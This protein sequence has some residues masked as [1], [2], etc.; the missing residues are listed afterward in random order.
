VLPRTPRPQA[1]SWA[2]IFS[3]HGRMLPRRLQDVQA[4]IVQFNS[5]TQAQLTTLGHGYSGDTTQQDGTTA[6]AM[7]SAVEQ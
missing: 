3:K 5:V 2:R 7:F 1:R 4:T 6:L